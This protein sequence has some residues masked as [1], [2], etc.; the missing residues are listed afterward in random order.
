MG[1][2]T[3]NF[4]RPNTLRVL[5]NSFG[6]HATVTHPQTPSYQFAPST[7]T[8]KGSFRTDGGMSN[9]HDDCFHD[10][11]D[12]C[13]GTLDALGLASSGSVRMTMAILRRVLPGKAE[14]Y[15]SQATA[16]SLTRTPSL[17]TSCGKDGAMPNPPRDPLL[18]PS[19]P[20]QTP[21]S[22]VHAGTQPLYEFS[23]QRRL[24]PACP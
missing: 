12:W 9:E 5:R 2:M 22:S 16:A 14:H 4:H 23:R 24:C 8:T 10:V 15:R 11:A 21:K 7:C 6:V 3:N 17:S 13:S 20:Q 19:Y 1:K 18:A